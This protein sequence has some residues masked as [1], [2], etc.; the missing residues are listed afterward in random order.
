MHFF[1]YMCFSSM[2]YLALVVLMFSVFS[3]RFSQYRLLIL[4]LTLGSTLLSYILTI[5]KLYMIIP[6]PIILIPL[7][8]WLLSRLFNDKY[9][10]CIVAT[11][12]SSVIYG[13]IQITVIKLFISAGFITYADTSNPY[14]FHTYTIQ[15]TCGF[16]GGVIALYI[17]STHSGFGF[18]FYKTINRKFIIVSIFSIIVCAISYS[19][20]I[21][22]NWSTAFVLT[23]LAMIMAA[24]YLVVLSHQQD[25]LEFS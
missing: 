18:S 14:G 17:R 6:T 24:V 1:G 12:G 21:H 25:K 15:A 4:S 3:F 9:S 19:L 5:T 22:T 2:E 8:A 7:I 16:I 13:L 20:T 23:L 10:Y 11:I